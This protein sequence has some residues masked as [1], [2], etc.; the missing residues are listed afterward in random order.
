MI[1]DGLHAGVASGGGATRQLNSTPMSRHSVTNTQL[2]TSAPVPP[3][4]AKSRLSAN[5]ELFAPMS[6]A[7]EAD[8]PPS[9]PQYTRPLSVS[10][11]EFTPM[12]LVHAADVVDSLSTTT[13]AVS[14]PD[15]TKTSMSHGR[16][17]SFPSA[18][19]AATQ[20]QVLQ[21][22]TLRSSHS[23]VPYP[24][25]SSS[26][27]AASS[28]S[29]LSST[30]DSVVYADIPTLRAGLPLRLL[31]PEHAHPHGRSLDPDAERRERRF[32]QSL[33]PF[34]RKNLYW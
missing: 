18:L 29:S 19:F 2:R 8:V 9:Y 23:A 20:S 7:H 1:G 5:A 30:D 14:T 21:T 6:L 25:S 10:A 15:A 17:S 3:S 11:K 34:F 4:Y 16:P 33:L 12:A 31:P 28:S 24:S 26:S 32:Q 27:S 22:S 13:G